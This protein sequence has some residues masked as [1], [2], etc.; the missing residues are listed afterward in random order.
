MGKTAFA[1]N[2]DSPFSDAIPGAAGVYVI[3]LVTN[4]PSSVPAFDEIKARVARDFELQQ[5]TAMARTAGTNFWISA[6]V[7]AATGKSLEQ[8]ASG[9][10][11]SAEKVAP[12]S[13]S[14]QDIPEIGEHVDLQT[15][16]AVAYHTLPGHLSPL[17]DSRDGNFLLYVK[18]ISPPDAVAKAA[19]LPQFTTQIR[20]QRENEAFSIWV[21]NE[22]SKE[23]AN[24][25][26]L[27]KALQP[28]H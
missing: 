6:A 21:N 26:A 24:M 25:P 20:R 2:A 28:N 9:R 8:I 27:Q 10:G 13:L 4:L 23:L 22:A 5:A 19:E 16:K 7:Q 18:S 11:L 14:S 12:F 3:G 1:L 17:L 15:Y